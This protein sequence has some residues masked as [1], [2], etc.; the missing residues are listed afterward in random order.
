MK[1][2]SFLKDKHVKRLVIIMVLWAV[3][4]AITRFSKFYT[5][6]NFQTMF[7]QFP[8]FGLM[9]LGVMVCMITSGIDLSVVG[10]ANTTAIA[11]ALLM[12][13]I[14]G[15]TGTMA[16][17]WIP[18]LFLF[19]IL[20]GTVAGALN[21]FLITTFDIPPILVTLGMGELFT[22]IGIVLTNGAAISDFPKDYAYVVN[23]RFAGIPVQFIIFALVAI[24]LAIILTKTTYGKK[25]M[26]IGT[27]QKAARFSGLKVNYLLIKTYIISGIC[28]ALGG[29]IMLA[30]YNSARADYGTNYTL[31]SILIVVLGGVSPAG[32]R[33][34][35][36]GVI[37]ATI[38]VRVLETGINRFP[39]ISSYYISLIWGAV[40]LFVMVLD[41]FSENNIKLLKRK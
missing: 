31:Q 32:G 14:G 27:S 19:A 18:I 37:L 36:S 24:V 2:T 23:S 33:G 30:N 17:F 29:M 15:D 8:E 1:K 25:I 39:Q 11:S 34:K 7:A 38:L 20:I 12:R 21:G 41:Y 16:V 28:A 6:I 4:M 10:V 26:M 40:L 13:S 5:V 3:F 35:I 22:G 9:S